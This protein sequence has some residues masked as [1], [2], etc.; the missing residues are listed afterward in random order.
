MLPISIAPVLHGI[1]MGLL[2]ALLALG[3]AQAQTANH[4]G[5]TGPPSSTNST[6]ST[7]SPSPSTSTSSSPAPSGHGP[8]PEYHLASPPPPAHCGGGLRLE[9]PAA[10]ENP[11]QAVA[12]LSRATQ[13]Y[14][15]ACRCDEQRCI[16]DALDEYA[17]TLA[18]VAPRLPKPLRNLP[19]IVAEAARHVRIAK[20]KAEAVT[21]L[22]RAIAAIHKDISLVR[23]EEIVTEKRGRRIGDLVASTLNVAGVQ[24]INSGGL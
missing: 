13:D 17:K 10:S 2:V 21:A 7:T 11:T 23:S 3:S 9:P 12:A 22:D 14:L 6:T 24:L 19:R 5:V 16:A 8:G 18:T 1:A 20:T 4:G 15:E